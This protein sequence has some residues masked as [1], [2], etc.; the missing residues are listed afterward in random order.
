MDKAI[1]SYITPELPWVHI[2]R[3][4][5]CWAF[6]FHLAWGFS[7]AVKAGCAVTASPKRATILLPGGKVAM[8]TD[9]SLASI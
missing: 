5:Q 1:A 9:C 2:H 4:L 6:P 8:G 3:L 7:V